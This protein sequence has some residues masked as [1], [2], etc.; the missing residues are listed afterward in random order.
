LRGEAALALDLVEAGDFGSFAGELVV[1]EAPAVVPELVGLAG[2]SERTGFTGD[3]VVGL[4]G[5]VAG[6]AAGR[7]LDRLPGVELAGFAGVLGRT[8]IVLVRLPEVIVAAL[9]NDVPGLAIVLLG[10][11]A[12]VLGLTVVELAVLAAAGLVVLD[13]VGERDGREGRRG[14]LRRSASACCS[15]LRLLSITLSCG[16]CDPMG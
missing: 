14:A 13:G 15:F 7:M 4:I 9:P 11:L 5:E 1:E 3:F 16:A 10:V 12:G 8:G 6:A 2:V